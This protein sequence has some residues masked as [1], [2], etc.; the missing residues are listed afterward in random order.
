MRSRKGR[1]MLWMV[2]RSPRRPILIPVLV[3]ESGGG[4]RHAHTLR[5]MNG[6][7][8]R[9]RGSHTNTYTHAHTARDPGTEGCTSPLISTWS[10]LSLLS[11]EQWALR[12][13][14]RISSV[15]VR[16]WEPVRGWLAQ[17]LPLPA[18]PAPYSSSSRCLLHLRLQASAHMSPPPRGPPRHIILFSPEH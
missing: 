7:T 13:K 1:F 2:A 16:T 14:P 12:R 17:P 11:Q 18:F 8:G 6:G 5:W 4:G 10:L 15:G 3:W 9:G